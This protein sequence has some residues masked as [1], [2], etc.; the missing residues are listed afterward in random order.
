MSVYL[1]NE[2]YP[3]ASGEKLLLNP[4]TTTQSSP[5]IENSSTGRIK[6]VKTT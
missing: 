6:V 5:N 1:A 2:L 4:A 3:L